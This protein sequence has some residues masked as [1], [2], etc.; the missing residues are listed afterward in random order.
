MLLT[1]A[2]YMNFKLFERDVRNAFLN[3]YILEDVYVEQPLDFEN[4]DF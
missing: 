4:K 1:F 3:G 2:S